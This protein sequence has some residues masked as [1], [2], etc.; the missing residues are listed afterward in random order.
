MYRLFSSGLVFDAFDA[1]QDWF[2]LIGG[3]L[4]VGFEIAFTGG[5]FVATEKFAVVAAHLFLVANGAGFWHSHVI[6]EMRGYCKRE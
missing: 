1:G 4:E 6:E 2:A 3:F 5:V